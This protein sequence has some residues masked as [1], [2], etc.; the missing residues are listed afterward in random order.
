MPAMFTGCDDKA[1]PTPPDAPT[2]IPP[3][4][5][6]S[7]RVGFIYSGEIAGSSHNRMWEDARKTIENQLGCETH[8]IENVFYVNFGEAVEILLAADV[9]VIVSTSHFFASAVEKEATK[10]R[11]ITFISHG[12]GTSSFNLATFQPLLFE[13]AHMAGF[14]AA[15]NVGTGIHD[16]GIVVDNRMFN[17]NAV[18]NSFILGARVDFVSG[19]NIHVSY[20]NSRSDTEVREAIDHF[21]TLNIDTVMCYLDTEYGI[22]YADS[23]GLKVVGFAN[24]IAELA[25]NNYIAGFYFDLNL[26]LTELVSL[27]Q[28]ATLQP[29][30]LRGDMQ[31]ATVR[32]SQLNPSEYTVSPD[33][34][35]VMNEL[36]KRVV[37]GHSPIFT[38]ELIDNHGTPQV[39]RGSHLNIHEILSMQWL[40]FSVANR[41]ID[42]VIIPS[43]LD[44][45]PLNIVPLP[46]TTPPP[47]PAT[48]PLE[49]G[50]TP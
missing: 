49:T 37:E 2:E 20:V 36:Q 8:Y 45:K 42:Y 17:V 28:T 13:P 18:I 21:R 32:L 43:E 16:I 10:N 34:Y 30:L 7:P 15:Y 23:R 24:N 27:V 14:A 46:A 5:I 1:P 38:G 40:E 22:T 29:R 33:T 48:A 11:D 9:D 25:P 4:P 6:R 35:R 26:H 39:L 19:V 44:I 12:G 50:D 41:T 47:P 31:S 3:E